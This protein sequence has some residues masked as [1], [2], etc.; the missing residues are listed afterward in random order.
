MIKEK[1]G[2]GEG[3]ESGGSWRFIYY[4]LFGFLFY[5]VYLGYR[6]GDCIFFRVVLVFR[7]LGFGLRGV[8][9]GEVRIV[10]KFFEF[11]G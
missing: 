11:C 4:F 8:G 3:N 9:G 2:G 6:I 5:S 1:D 7:F 10:G